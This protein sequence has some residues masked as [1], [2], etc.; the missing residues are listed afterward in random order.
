ML[1]G[2]LMV[3]ASAGFWGINIWEARQAE[4]ET[5]RTVILLQEQIT[6]VRVCAENNE[7]KSGDFHKLEYSAS[8]DYLGLLSIPDLNRI[9]PV[10]IEWNYPALRKTPCRYSGS[11]EEENLIILAHNYEAHFGGL[12]GLKPG[13]EI[14]FT[15]MDGFETEY[16]V[17]D[18]R[19][20]GPQSVDEMTEGDW[21]LI[22]FTCTYGGEKR[23]VVRCCQK[24]RG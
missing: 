1:L 3:F 2:L 13:A 20:L 16:Q 19:T 14:I 10:G 8:G 12:K 9:L 21:Q 11:V 6:D 22:L 5:E 23:V 24:S 15:G 18:V 7:G 4:K 17:A